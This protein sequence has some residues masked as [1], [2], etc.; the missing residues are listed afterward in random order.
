MNVATLKLVSIVVPSL[1]IIFVVLLSLGI[2]YK[3]MKFHAKQ[4]EATRR[5]GTY[6]DKGYRSYTRVT[7]LNEKNTNLKASKNLTTQ[8]LRTLAEELV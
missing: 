4:L 3:L 2:V 7:L 1:V 8:N 6:F 5:V